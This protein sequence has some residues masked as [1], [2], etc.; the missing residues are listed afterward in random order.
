MS[1]FGFDKAW[2]R[3]AGVAN[4]T[5]ALVARRS[6]IA[7]AFRDGV[8][9]LRWTLIRSQVRSVGARPARTFVLGVALWSRPDL[10]ALEDLAGIGWIRDK[11]IRVEI[12]DIDEFPT[13]ADRAAVMPGVAPS[14]QTPILAEYKH[15]RLVEVF[16]GPEVSRWCLESAGGDPRQNEEAIRPRRRGGWSRR[17]STA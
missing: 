2:N 5:A 17:G 15:G 6:A 9:R 13:L 10:A 1:V 7:A 4:S 8:Q 11:G 3:S 16:V 12:F 14:T